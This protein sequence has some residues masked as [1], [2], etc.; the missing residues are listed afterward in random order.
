MMDKVTLLTEWEYN[1][2]TSWFSDNPDACNPMSLVPQA[3]GNF[4]EAVNRAKLICES[5]ASYYSGKVEFPDERTFAREDGVW[6]FVAFNDAGK[7]VRS[8]TLHLV[9]VR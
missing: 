8:V 3:Y 6:E 5:F 9:N 7:R 1:R 4:N 2:T